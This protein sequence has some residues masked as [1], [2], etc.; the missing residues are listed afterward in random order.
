MLIGCALLRLAPRPKSRSPFQLMA[1][2]EADHQR[3]P[4]RDDDSILIHKEK[5]RLVVLVPLVSSVI[6]CIPIIRPNQRNPPLVCEVCKSP[7]ADNSV[8]NSHTIVDLERARRIDLAC[9][10]ESCSLA[11]LVLG[12]SADRDNEAK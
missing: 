11:A 5:I 2:H 9:D 1:F 7:S 10:G 12:H 8:S 3:E 6:K 4:L